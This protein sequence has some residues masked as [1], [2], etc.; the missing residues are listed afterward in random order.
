MK[1]L[2]K[3]AAV[4]VILGA[5]LVGYVFYTISSASKLTEYDFGLDKIPSINAIIGEER[6]VTKVGSGVSTSSGQSKEYT[7]ESASVPKD[8][9]AYSQYLR[10]KDWLVTRDF[11]LNASNG[12][13]ELAT[14]SADKGKILV[15]SV[16]FDQKQYVVKIT[17]AD[18][19]LTRK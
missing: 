2:L 14:E 11:N 4:L 13:M 7:Y 16:A 9:L 15:V 5:I 19:T 6:K 18:G 3:I 12:V 17:K 1:K 10:S 8:L